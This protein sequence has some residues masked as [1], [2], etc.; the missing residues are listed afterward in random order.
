MEMLTQDGMYGSM[1]L[2]LII[3]AELLNDKRTE[4]S[5]KRFMDDVWSLSGP[6]AE[7][8]EDFIAAYAS[9]DIINNTLTPYLCL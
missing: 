1:L 5:T 8:P 7:L 9:H 4:D 2:P 6:S 3:H